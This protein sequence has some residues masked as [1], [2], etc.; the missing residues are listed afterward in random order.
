MM[1]LLFRK[2]IDSFKVAIP[3]LVR[4]TQNSRIS[5][6]FDNHSLTESLHNGHT[7]VTLHS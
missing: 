6:K 2:V 1:T 4:K 5:T 7:S 3:V